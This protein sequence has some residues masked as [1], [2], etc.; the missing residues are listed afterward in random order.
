MSQ[1]QQLFVLD[2]SQLETK[3]KQ[4]KPKLENDMLFTTKNI[5][6]HHSFRLLCCGLAVFTLTVSPSFADSGCAASK[7]SGYQKEGA[8]P[9]PQKSE[10]IVG[11]WK[12]RDM[13]K[14]MDFEINAK[15]GA[16]GQFVMTGINHSDLDGPQP[17][18]VSGSYSIEGTALITRSRG[19]EKRDEFWFENGT[20]L[21]K[22]NAGTVLLDFQ[23]VS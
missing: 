20:L 23:R 15:F 6:N 1:L 17:P 10:T 4:T 3:P 2:V 19:E 16:D 12:F 5:F 7:C 13:V 11:S 22:T 9:D 14:G 21:I 18:P 8:I